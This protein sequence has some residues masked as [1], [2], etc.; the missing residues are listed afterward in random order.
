M[1]CA[2]G[3]NDFLCDNIPTAELPQGENWSYV[4][5][6]ELDSLFKLQATQIDTQERQQTFHSISKIIFDKAYFVGLWNDPDFWA[7]NPR[8][9]N[10]QLSG[11]TPFFNIREWD[12]QP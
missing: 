7:A 8:L 3:T 11:I 4:C 2:P 12:V 10:V 5:D 1:G 6:E 9:K